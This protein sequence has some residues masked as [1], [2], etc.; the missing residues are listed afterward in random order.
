GPVTLLSW[1]PAAVLTSPWTMLMARG[2]LF[3]GIGLWAFNLGLPWSC[4]LTTAGFTAVWSLHVENTHNTAHIYNLPNMLLVIQ[5][6]WITADA[7]RIRAAL[8]AGAYWQ[9]PLA[10]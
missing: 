9:T 6:L 5:S 1:L 8:A 2:L 7:P 10:P 4:W 3:V